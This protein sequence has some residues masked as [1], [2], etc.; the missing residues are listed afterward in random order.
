VNV[1]EVY[2]PLDSWQK[3]LRIAFEKVRE[4]AKEHPELVHRYRA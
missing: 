4:L 2:E 3:Q 1:Y